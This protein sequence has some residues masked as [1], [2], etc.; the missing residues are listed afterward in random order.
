MHWCWLGWPGEERVFAHGASP[1]LVALPRFLTFL[2]LCG[3][4]GLDWRLYPRPTLT[5]FNQLSFLTYSFIG[6]GGPGGLGKIKYDIA[7]GIF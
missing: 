6:L 4:G 5:G 2:T 7:S 1:L 3:Q